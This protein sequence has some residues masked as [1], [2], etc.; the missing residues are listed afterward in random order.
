MSDFDTVPEPGSGPMFDRIASRYDLLN[1]VISLGLD[2]GWRRRTAKAL[3]L[4]P[5]GCVLDLATGTADLALELAA[6][7]P[8][9][10]VVGLDQA[11]RMLAIGARKVERRGLRARVELVRGDASEL[12]FPA[13]SFAAC[14]MAFG[15]RNMPD[16]MRVLG[17]LRRVLRPGGRV[18]ILELTEPGGGWLGR[19]A[20]CHVHGLVPRVGALLSG[21]EAYRYLARSIAAFPPPGEFVGSLG[22]AGFERTRVEA[23]TWGVAHLYVGDAA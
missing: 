4:A 16:R 18:A 12:P 6:T 2:R 21:A 13:A 9:A 15:I 10:R 8:S 5:D 17:E 3:E 23:M 7:Y 11:S 19:V 20:R 22:A 1:R 14:T